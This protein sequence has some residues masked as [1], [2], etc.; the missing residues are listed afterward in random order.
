MT[1]AICSASASS[2]TAGSAG[3]APFASGAAAS[4]GVRAGS[5]VF[6]MAA[7]RTEGLLDCTPRSGT[8]LL[9]A[10]DIERL[11]RHVAALVAGEEDHHV[12]YVVVGAAAAERDLLLV[13]APHL[14]D[15]DPP[16][17]RLLVVEA[18][19]PEGA[20]QEVAGA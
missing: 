12:R 3:G 13:L 11:P 1:R 19:L 18:L 15:R 14:L 2:L 17:L 5:I 6:A 9:P 16:L 10:G 4:G 8:H 7:S 20:V